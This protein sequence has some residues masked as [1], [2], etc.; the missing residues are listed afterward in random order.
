MGIAATFAAALAV[1]ATTNAAGVATNS[2]GSVRDWETAELRAARLKYEA[3][4][5]RADEALAEVK[6]VVERHEAERKRLGPFRHTLPPFRSED[7]RREYE[8]R[9]RAEILD[10]LRQIDRSAAERVRTFP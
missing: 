2:A 6:A 10:L 4:V 8:I 9:Q 5:K 7:E 1:A 3:A